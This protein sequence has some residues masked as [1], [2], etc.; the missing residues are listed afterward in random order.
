MRGYR[1]EVLA[2]AG[3]VMEAVPASRLRRFYA[4]GQLVMVYRG[5]SIGWVQGQV[6]AKCSEIAQTTEG[7]S[8]AGCASTA[9]VNA[10]SLRSGNSL[11]SVGCEPAGC[12]NTSADQFGTNSGPKGVHADL[13]PMLQVACG[14]DQGGT[15][16]AALKLESIPTY[17]V[18]SLETSKV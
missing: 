16:Q 14:T 18:S 3:A 6:L 7:A 5:P 8:P 12:G 4:S 17:L 9:C 13:W 11:A 10:G 1:V 2:G 15:Q